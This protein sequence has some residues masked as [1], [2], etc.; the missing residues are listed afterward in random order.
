M[1]QRNS[2]RQRLKRSTSKGSFPQG[3]DR[4][5]RSKELYDRFGEWID[6]GG[7]PHIPALLWADGV[8]SIW[9]QH[10]QEVHTHSPEPGPRVAHCHQWLSDDGTLSVLSPYE[11][12]GYFLEI[13]AVINSLED[14]SPRRISRPLRSSIRE[15]NLSP[16]QRFEILVEHNFRC[17]YCGKSPLRDGITLEID[18]IEPRSQ[19]GSH[20]KPNRVPACQAC[21][22]GKSD[23]I[24]I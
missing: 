24:I 15:S 20:H 1:K 13:V 23:R 17:F 3:F 7:K 10:C 21:N 6:A 19:G 16:K 8:A 18:H 9:C 2:S 22:R 5:F 11:K 12:T 4:R 14:I